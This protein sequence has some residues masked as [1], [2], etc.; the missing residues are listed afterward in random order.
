M[1]FNRITDSLSALLFCLFFRADI[2]KKGYKSAN[3]CENDKQWIFTSSNV[4]Y[5]CLI[6]MEGTLHK[7]TYKIHA[8]NISATANSIEVFFTIFLV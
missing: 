6:T 5:K 7:P 8:F 2:K 1:L 3:Y 4:L